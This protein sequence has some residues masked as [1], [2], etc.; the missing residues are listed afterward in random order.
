MS[1]QELCEECSPLLSEAYQQ[2]QSSVAKRLKLEDDRQPVQITEEVLREEFCQA[3]G[4]LQKKENFPR[5]RLAGCRAMHLVDLF[6][7]RS[8]CL[9]DPNSVRSM[10][11]WVN[12]EVVPRM[13]NKYRSHISRD[14]GDELP[15]R[16]LE[17]RESSSANPKDPKPVR[18]RKYLGQS[19]LKVWL[20]I[21]FRNLVRDKRRKWK[22]R[23]DAEPLLFDVEKNGERYE[24]VTSKSP[25]IRERLRLSVIQFLAK[26]T[27]QQ[28]KVFQLRVVEG[29]T[30]E[31]C[32][33]ELGCEPGNVSD[34]LKNFLENLCKDEIFRDS[35][36]AIEKEFGLQPN[37]ITQILQPVSGIG[38]TDEKQEKKHRKTLEDDLGK[39]FNWST[40]EDTPDDRLR[41][42]VF[43]AF[44]RA[45]CRLPAEQKMVLK[46]RVLDGLS[47]V[48]AA[49]HMFCATERVVRQFDQAV[50][51]VCR[52][53]QLAGELQ[54]LEMEFDRPE[55]E[56][57]D[58]MEDASTAW[59]KTVFG[60][61]DDSR[62]MI[63]EIEN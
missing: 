15:I 48:T 54:W 3:F 40:D 7:A 42:D 5:G 14:A 21:V 27:V 1:C 35:L 23:K 33:A 56:L 13:L 20:A 29:R 32:A 49:S 60:W 57:R 2:M 9:Y 50:L 30:N 26:R 43:S 36:V 19:S 37:S 17:P 63:E 8:A 58:G 39:L 24:N 31:D 61:I 62:G 16:L 59:L 45:I 34:R 52:D 41:Q 18:L 10:F 6:W 25:S 44:V 55:H 28:K 11:K 47:P 53:R 12:E 51:K 4:E 38:E 22:L 46:L